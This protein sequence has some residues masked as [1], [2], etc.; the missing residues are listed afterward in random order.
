MGIGVE[1]G[2]AYP[3]KEA[4]DAHFDTTIGKMSHIRSRSEQFEQDAKKKGGK[5]GNHSC[6]VQPEKNEIKAK[7][8]QEAVVG[9]KKQK[10]EIW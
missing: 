2:M 6:F 3:E 5:G 1:W 7:H 10:K 9:G 8:E 4:S